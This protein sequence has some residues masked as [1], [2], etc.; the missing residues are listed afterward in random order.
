MR[1]WLSG[2]RI[3]RELVVAC[4]IALALG[5]VTAV[6]PARAAGDPWADDARWVSFRVGMAKTA[7]ERAPDGGLGYGFGYTRFLDPR[8]SWGAFVHHEVVGRFGGAA[9]I[10]MPVTIEFVRH[11]AWHTQ[12]RPYLGMG[13]GTFFAKTY[14]TGADES[15]FRTGVYLTTGLNVPL[16]GTSLIGFDMRM[17]GERGTRSINPVFANSKPSTL[18][19]SLKLN[20]SRVL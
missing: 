6:A 13:W 3:R 18:G 9:E 15:K 14:R 10:E 5:I 8:W 4:V 16:D 11:M 19:W 1:Q 12:A 17:I 2:R 20:Y 7:A